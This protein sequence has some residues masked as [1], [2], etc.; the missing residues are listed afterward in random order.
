MR[1]FIIKKKTLLKVTLCVLAVVGIGLYS[2][3]SGVGTKDV[4]AGKNNEKMPVCSA[5]MNSK[6][7]A[8]T[9]DTAFGEDHTLQILDVLK[10]EGVKAT[11]FVMGAWGEENSDAVLRM[12]EE[13]HDIQSHSM[14]HMRYTDVKVDEMIADALKAKEYMESVTG[15]E[16]KYIRLPYGAF[17]ENVLTELEKN[18]FVPMKWSVDGKDW[19]TED[20]REVFNNVLSDIK[21]GDIVMLQNNTESGYLAIGEIIKALKEKGYEF[22]TVSEL[23]PDGPLVTD[24]NGKATLFDE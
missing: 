10:A 6:K 7:I 18:G 11:F 5:E 12:I 15:K 1:V 4:F 19:Q 13:G 22:L 20:T 16:S 24:E 14:E 2:Q 9:I 3:F 23:L 21:G 17:D 8:L